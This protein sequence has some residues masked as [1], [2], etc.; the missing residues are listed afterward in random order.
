MAKVRVRRCFLD[1]VEFDVLHGNIDCISL[2]CEAAAYQ[3]IVQAGLDRRR[4]KAW[5][6]GSHWALS[7]S[8]ELCG[9]GSAPTQ[10]HA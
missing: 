1:G 5:F 9:Q 8:R 4:I 2:L 3:P 7:I 6:V 10:P